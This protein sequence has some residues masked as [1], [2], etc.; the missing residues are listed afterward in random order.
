M[1]NDPLKTMIYKRCELVCRKCKQCLQFE[2]VLEQIDLEQR[3]L[4][5]RQREADKEKRGKEG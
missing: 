3:S 4:L 2:K 5:E 1:S